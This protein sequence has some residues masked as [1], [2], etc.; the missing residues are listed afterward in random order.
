[1]CAGPMSFSFGW[2]TRRNLTSDGLQVL[3]VPR[4]PVFWSPVEVVVTAHIARDFPEHDEA[5]SVRHNYLKF[6]VISCSCVRAGNT[7]MWN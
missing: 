1:M 4:F 2:T 6:L 7:W 3:V 5:F